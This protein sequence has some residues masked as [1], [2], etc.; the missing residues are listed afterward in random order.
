[1]PHALLMD[2]PRSEKELYNALQE[3]KTTADFWGHAPHA[4]HP[5]NEP[6]VLTRIT[7]MKD[8]SI[9]VQR[10][11]SQQLTICG[12]LIPLLLEAFNLDYNIDQPEVFEKLF[13]VACEIH[14]SNYIPMRVL[15]TTVE[16]M[17]K[18]NKS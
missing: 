4:P 17:I 13:W 2:V 11:R 8:S 16:G 14:S 7:A 3:A 15:G 18:P 12:K 10:D 5:V 1:M 6:A 9:Q